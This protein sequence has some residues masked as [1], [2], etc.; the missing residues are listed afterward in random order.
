M[1]EREKP[2][3][4][5]PCFLFWP[6]ATSPSPATDATDRPMQSLRS[7][8]VRR[9]CLLA[10]APATRPS[11][12]LSLPALWC[13]TRPLTSSS[14]RWDSGAGEFYHQII[15]ETK[16]EK[17]GEAEDVKRCVILPLPAFRTLIVSR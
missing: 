13:R 5:L 17:P 8:S 3:L 1:S 11:P 10:V 7:T 9:L 2:Y 6:C 16:K 15:E 12:T 4:A 14:T